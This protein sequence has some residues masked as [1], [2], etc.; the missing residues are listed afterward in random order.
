MN[1]GNPIPEVKQNI[2]LTPP[3]SSEIQ[4]SSG[5]SNGNQVSSNFS[6]NTVVTTD[7]ANPFDISSMF[8]NNQ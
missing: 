6:E 3:I 4:G 2:P 7:G 1:M 8:T 5:V